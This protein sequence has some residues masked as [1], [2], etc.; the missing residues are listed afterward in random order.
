M[1]PITKCFTAKL[2]YGND[3]HSTKLLKINLTA[4][5]DSAREARSAAETTDWPGV[6]AHWGSISTSVDLGL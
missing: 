2:L 1:L 3:L 4:K 5:L 6:A